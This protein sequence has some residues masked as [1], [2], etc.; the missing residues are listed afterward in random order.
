MTGCKY[1]QQ[2]L[3]IIDMGKDNWQGVNIIR[4]VLLLWST[5][6]IPRQEHNVAINNNNDYLMSWLTKYICKKGN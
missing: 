1:Y 2:E 3:D 6:H 4:D 5:I